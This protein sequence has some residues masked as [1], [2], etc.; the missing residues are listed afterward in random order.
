MEVKQPA[1]QPAGLAKQSDAQ[2]FQLVGAGRALALD[3]CTPGPEGW[4]GLALRP[5]APFHRVI[6]HPLGSPVP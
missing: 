4:S 1:P 6:P 3:A 2:V 5:L